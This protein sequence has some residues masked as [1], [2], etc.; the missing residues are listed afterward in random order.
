MTSR[1]APTRCVG[2]SPPVPIST[3][4]SRKT[5]R[6]ISCVWRI[7]TVNGTMIATGSGTGCQNR[8][9]RSSWATRRSTTQTRVDLATGIQLRSE[10]LEE[11]T[12]AEIIAAER[13][14][15]FPARVLRGSCTAGRHRRSLFHAGR[16]YRHRRSLSGTSQHGSGRRVQT[17]PS[18]TGPR[19]P[20]SRSFGACVRKLAAVVGE[21]PGRATW[22]SSTCYWITARTSTPGATGWATPR[23]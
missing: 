12:P 14:K 2:W 22:R 9:L 23:S 8:S 13:R 1:P 20:A 15:R 11:H 16:W 21:P 4:R 3:C 18:G 7:G 10:L 6:R 17:G 5:E 19:T